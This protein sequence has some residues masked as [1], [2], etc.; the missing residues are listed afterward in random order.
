[1]GVI[2]PLSPLGKVIL[3]LIAIALGVI[4]SMLQWPD[5]WKKHFRKESYLKDEQQRKKEE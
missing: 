4:F 3:I 2:F 5:W 1:M